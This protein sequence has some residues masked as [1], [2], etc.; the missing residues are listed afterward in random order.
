MNYPEFADRDDVLEYA[1]QLIEQASLL[2]I[3]GIAA[4]RKRGREDAELRMKAREELRT[5]MAD[6]IRTNK[7]RTDKDARSVLRHLADLS[8]DQRH[9]MYLIDA[10]PLAWKGWLNINCIHRCN[11]NWVPPQ[12]EYRIE[13]TDEGRKVLAAS[14]DRRVPRPG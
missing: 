3:I 10:W 5:E 7:S 12:V 13:I 6:L 2:D 8:S 4:K 11:S 1:A 14:L 9:D